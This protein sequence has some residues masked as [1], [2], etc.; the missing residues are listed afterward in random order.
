MYQKLLIN[1]SSREDNWCLSFIVIVGLVKLAGISD[2][3]A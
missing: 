1:Y 2:I 3:D